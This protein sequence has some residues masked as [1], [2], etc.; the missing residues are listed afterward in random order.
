VS[1]QEQ[2]KVAMLIMAHADDTEFDGAGTATLWAREGWD[3]YLVI[4]TDG[5]AGG[6]EDA[7]E[8][9]LAARQ[10]VVETRQKEQ[11]AAGEIL[12]LKDVFF[13]G[14]PDGQL[15]PTLEVRR[16]IVRLLRRYRP[17]RV[18]CQTPDRT[19][20]PS[21][22][23]PRHHPD[24]LAAGQAA[25]GAIYPGSQN[26]W[27]FP[28]LLNE[29]LRPH[30]VSEVYITTPPVQNFAIDITEVMDLKVAALRAHKSQV[31][32]EADE[33]EQLIRSID[34][35]QGKPYGFAYAEVFHRVENR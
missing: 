34:A 6:P 13:L 4:C 22:I 20:T 18:I 30:K 10:R 14:Y 3:V 7:T 29:G 11:L 21:L 17:S 26:L 5:G 33:L 23:I 9:S 12:G 28:E 27:D 1:E 31:G 32:A 35:E 8:V 2:N 24:H 19:W 16:D 25:L 15:Q